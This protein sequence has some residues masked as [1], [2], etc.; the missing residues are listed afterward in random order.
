MDAVHLWS[1]CCL[2]TVLGVQLCHPADDPQLSVGERVTSDMVGEP[3][4]V[5][6]NACMV[7][8]SAAGLLAR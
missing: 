8:W 6:R 2:P 3:S 7:A 5:H 1:Q 4:C